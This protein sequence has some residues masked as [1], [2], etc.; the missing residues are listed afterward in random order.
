[1]SDIVGGQ[2]SISADLT[3]EDAERLAVAI[4]KYAY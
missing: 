2:F 1:M 4:T 3:K